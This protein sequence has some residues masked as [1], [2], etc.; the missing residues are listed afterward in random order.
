MVDLASTAH[1]EGVNVGT[2]HRMKGLKF[3]CLIV[4][5]VGE[6]SV[7]ARAA[8]TPITDDKHAHALDMQRERCLLFVACT[9]AREEL[10]VSW[11]GMVSPFVEPMV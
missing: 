6:H 4:A 1:D 9:R 3:R 11:N 5:G 8:V 7:P 10:L 2:M